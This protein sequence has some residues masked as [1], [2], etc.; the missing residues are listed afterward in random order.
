MPYQSASEHPAYTYLDRYWPIQV[1]FADSDKP[2]KLLIKEQFAPFAEQVYNAY[3]HG[4]DAYSVIDGLTN[5]TDKL[6][7]PKIPEV[8]VE[9]GGV[10]VFIV[11]ILISAAI[12]AVQHGIE[13]SR[14]KLHTGGTMGEG[15]GIGWTPAGGVIYREC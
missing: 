11:R 1:E 13:L 7:L 3:K 9:F 14:F 6:Q 8:T 12:W 10:A 4:S 5:L 15:G 2:I